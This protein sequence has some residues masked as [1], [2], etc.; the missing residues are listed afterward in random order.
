VRARHQSS[1]RISPSGEV[2]QHDLDDEH[3]PAGQANQTG[4]RRGGRPASIVSVTTHRSVV[5]TKNNILDLR[6]AQ[7]T[8]DGAYA[9]TALGQLSY[10]VVI[11]RLFQN[12]FYFV[13]IAYVVLAIGL[14]MLSVMRYKLTMESPE[15][16]HDDPE[17]E[18]PQQPHRS[19]G[20]R[21]RSAAYPSFASSL[22]ATFRRR[23][24]RTSSSGIEHDY[25]TAP[26]INDVFRTAGDV[27]AIATAFTLVLL[28]ALLVLVLRL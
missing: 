19:D 24:R 9:R 18:Q 22:T 6:A 12:E 5:Y 1:A 7:R 17:P 8:F 21:P 13:G 26:K 23:H 11:L 2:D 14:L 28:I 20:A 27:V 25:R 15:E 4:S 3:E 10:A 16:T